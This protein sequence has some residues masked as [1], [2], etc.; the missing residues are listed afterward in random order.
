MLEP[1]PG[2]ANS[3]VVNTILPEPIFSKSGRVYV[4]SEIVDTVAL[5]LPSGVP[6]DT[7][8]YYTLD[9][10][11][12][13]VNSLS[14]KNPVFILDTTTVIRAKLLSK[15]AVSPYTSTHSYIFHPRDCSLPVVSINTDDEYLYGS[16]LG[17]LHGSYKDANPNY[18]NDWRRPVNL[19]FFMQDD[20]AVIN[21]LCEVRVQG[22]GSR[23]YNQKSL[24]VYAKKRFGKNRFNYPLWEQKPGV[25]K[26]K[27]FLLRNSGNDCAKTHLR[28]A[29]VQEYYATYVDNLDY[30]AYEPTVCYVN[31]EYKGIYNIRERSNDDYVDANYDGLEDFD[32]IENWNSL[33]CGDWNRFV[34]YLQPLISNPKTTYEEISKVIDVDN[35]LKLFVLEFW[36]GNTDFP[37]N[38]IVMWRPK[39]TDGKWRW[40]IKDLDFVGSSGKSDP[41]DN[42]LDFI[43]RTNDHANDNAGANRKKA[44][45]LFQFM[46]GKQEFLTDF[47]NY[48]SV[49][50]GDFLHPELTSEYFMS[51][52]AEIESEYAYHTLAYNYFNQPGNIENHNI[53]KWYVNISKFTDWLKE[54]NNHVYHYLSDYFNLGNPIPVTIGCNEYDVEFNG[55]SLTQPNFEG[56]Y[57][58]GRD[59][60]LKVPGG[61]DKNLCW[62]I[63]Y[64]YEKSS[65]VN[66]LSG[67]EIS[68][69]L[70]DNC[71]SVDIACVNKLSVS[72][73]ESD[74]KVDVNNNLIIID[75]FDKLIDNIEVY[76]A[77]GVLV[78]RINKVSAQSH[79]INLSTSGMYVVKI[80]LYSGIEI[81]EKVFI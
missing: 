47:I 81:I 31:G 40:V 18:K 59:V 33:K 21:Q 29:F 44:V 73:V 17:I 39:T 78:E 12:P 20:D 32:M 65:A 16:E 66:Y 15:E 11:F 6:E 72:D 75:A 77:Y 7:K 19:E 76:D 37:G 23:I 51:M 53:D 57:F 68:F 25:Q 50:L 8:I 54:R 42:Y 71:M 43:L 80:C 36:C 61:G 49:Y 62:R 58:A 63:T 10:S 79:Q 3:I 1:T 67:N 69:V 22:G 34:N 28:D 60:M 30:Q 64:K 35:F 70:P 2:T 52:C 55:V 46:I 5:S 45:E 9:G 26:V 4:N 13:N 27:S 74:V 38:N 41:N 56:K 14:A 48:T 24:A